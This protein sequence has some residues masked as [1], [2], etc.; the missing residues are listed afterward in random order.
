MNRQDLRELVVDTLLGVAPEI[1]ANALDPDVNFR[2]QAELDSVDYL[3]FVLS[4]EQRLSLRIPEVD[5]PR[6]SGLNGCLLYLHAR[7]VGTA[8]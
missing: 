6:L 5:Y 7:G 4:L 1:D 2:D 3:N 8:D